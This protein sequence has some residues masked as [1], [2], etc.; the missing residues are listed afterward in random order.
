MLTSGQVY[1]A[2]VFCA[3][4][5]GFFGNQEFSSYVLC[6]LF[7]GVCVNVN[8]CIKSSNILIS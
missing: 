3:Q 5:E 8:R 4:D 1:S 2:Y 7:V 6:F